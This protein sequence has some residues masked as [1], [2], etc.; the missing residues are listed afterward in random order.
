MK[1]KIIAIII[2]LVVAVAGCFAYILIGGRPVDT[3]NK[4]DIFVNIDQGS[5]TEQIADKLEKAKVIRSGLVFRIKTMLGGEAEKFKAGTYQFNQTMSTNRVIWL[6]ANGKTAGKSFHVLPREASYKIAATLEEKGICSKDEFFSECKDGSFDFPFMDM[7][8]KGENRLE[9]FLWPE[10]YIVSLDG[11]AHEAVN[12]M[13]RGFN[14]NAYSKYKDKV[15]EKGLDFYK[16][17]VKAS[18]IEGEASDPDDMKKVSS[19]IDNRLKKGMRLQMDSTLNYIKK[20]EKVISSLSDTELE[21]KYNTY[22]YAGL[23]PGPICSPGDDAI[24]AA[25]NPDDTD[26]LFFVNSDKL[27]GTLTFTKTEKD[28][29]KAKAKFEKAYAEYLKKNG[30][31]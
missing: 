20:E 22:K 11:G 23:P 3:S 31:Q 13:L 18:I 1:K 26:Y 9:G 4:S 5:S 25:V 21:S 16:T 19:V 30:N 29:N 27:D 10:T 8:P 7:L 2:I 6:I 17:I 28:H 15:A 12:Q 24:N 14:D